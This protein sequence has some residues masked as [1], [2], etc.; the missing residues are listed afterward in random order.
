MEAKKNPRADIYQQ[1]SKFFLIGLIVSISLV[2][3]AFEWQSEK[4]IYTK[5][6]DDSPMEPLP[7]IPLT[8]I[9]PS[10]VITPPA[11]LPKKQTV[12]TPTPTDFTEVTNNTPTDAPPVIDIE[13]PETVNQLSPEPE[14]DTIGFVIGAEVQPKP[15][16]GLENFYRIISHNIKYPTVARKIGTEGK[17]LVE[18]VVDRKGNATQIKILKG[19]GSGCDEEAMRVIALPKWE[20]GRQRGKTV[21]VKMVMPVNFRLGEI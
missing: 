3:T 18:F 19:I 6:A 12:V 13:I 7:Y 9:Q 16:G 5:P 2:I 17:V 15:V 14:I 8:D 4:R 1:R 10:K 20:A 21:N 11:V